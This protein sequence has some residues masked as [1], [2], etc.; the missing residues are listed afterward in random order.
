MPFD[1]A[2]LAAFLDPTMPGYAVA[3]IDEV[4]I[5]GLF[6]KPYSESFGLV[7]GDNPQFRALSSALASVAP[8]DCLTL[9]DASYTVASVR[10]DGRGMIVLDLK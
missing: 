6:R 2:D 4:A 5:G 3:T 10:P 8:G 1:A 7:G 9:E